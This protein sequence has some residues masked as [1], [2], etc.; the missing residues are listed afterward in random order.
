M[1]LKDKKPSKFV[2]WMFS[3]KSAEMLKIVAVTA[4]GLEERRKMAI[5]AGS[6]E[7]LTKPFR[8]EKLVNFIAK[9]LPIEFTFNESKKI[10]TKET[11]P[12]DYNVK[13]IIQFLNQ[14]GKTNQKV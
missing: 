9:L 2:D 10:T 1:V 5:D 13:A 11:S 4:W 3:P 6:D 14:I 12:E 7:F 8:V